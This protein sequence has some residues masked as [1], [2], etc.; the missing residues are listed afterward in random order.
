METID[1]D[2]NVTAG[3]THDSVTFRLAS[4]QEDGVAVRLE[5]QIPPGV[6]ASQ[7]G[8]DA[9]HETEPWSTSGDSLVFVRRLDPGETVETGYTVGGVD[10]STVR[11]MLRSVTVEVR[12]VDGAALERIDGSELRVDGESLEA[13]DDSGGPETAGLPASVSDY[14]LRDVEEIDSS[15]FEWATVDEGDTSGGLLSRLVPFL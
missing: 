13:G 2:V 12:D 5:Q 3:S 15:E 7:V 1:V 9:R 14:V 11:R 6:A 8:V 4:D 10:T